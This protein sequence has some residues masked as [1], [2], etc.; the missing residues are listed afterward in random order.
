[1]KH[2]ENVWEDNNDGKSN[3]STSDGTENFS[4]TQAS[5]SISIRYLGYFGFYKASNDSGNPYGFL[6]TNGVLFDEAGSKID[7]IK[8]FYISKREL[9]SFSEHDWVT[10]EVRGTTAVNL[11]MA[12]TPDGL[13]MALQ[14]YWEHPCFKGSDDPWGKHSYDEHAIAGPLQAFLN[15]S[16]NGPREF[17]SILCECAAQEPERD[18]FLESLLHDPKTRPL[19]QNCFLQ[20]PADFDPNELPG[21]DFVKEK[22][23]DVL[24]AEDSWELIG[25]LWQKGFALKKLSPALQKKLLEGDGPGK[26]AFVAGL[27]TAEIA[28]LLT[29]ADLS[30]VSWE[31]SQ[32]L[33]ERDSS[34]FTSCFPPDGRSS[35]A[36]L[37]FLCLCGQKSCL[38]Y[39]QDWQNIA[40]LLER[41]EEYIGPFLDRYAPIAAEEQVLGL[42]AKHGAIRDA[43]LKRILPG[44][45]QEQKA[46]SSALFMKVMLDAELEAEWNWET[47]VGCLSHGISL[48]PWHPM[49]QKKLLEGD[50]PG[51]EAFVAG[52]STAEIAE[53]LSGADLSS[54]SWELAQSLYERDSSVFT[55][56]FPP[57]GRSSDSALF[58]LC[59]CGQTDGLVCIRD[60]QNMA[61]LLERHE[62]YV[63]PFLDRYAPIA[64]DE[65]VL[66]LLAKRS[67]IRNA[68]RKRIL[69]EK[70]QEQKAASSALFMKVILDEEL[71]AEWDW[72]TL[73]ECLLHD[74]SLEPW[75]PM[76]RKK[77]ADDPRAKG[78]KDFLQHL[79]AAEVQKLFAG[80]QAEE[81]SWELTETLAECLLHGISLEPWHLMI[82]K[83]LTDDPRAKGVK[84]FLQ[85]LD[86][87]EAQKLFAG[88]QAEEFSWELT[89]TL[90][91]LYGEA[92]C[93]IVPPMDDLPDGVL[94]LL[95]QC[96]R[97][98][99]IG[100]IANWEKLLKD[101]ETKYLC[102]FAQRFSGDESPDV[103][104][105][106]SRM[107]PDVLAN[108][109]RPL[110]E[111]E[112]SKALS[113]FADMDEQLTLAAAMLLPDNALTED[114]RRQR[115][116]TFRSDLPY[117][118]FDLESDRDRDTIW[119][120]AF[121]Q[122][123]ETRKYEGEEQLSSLLRRLKKIPNHRWP[124]YT[125][126]GSAHPG[127]ARTEDKCFC[128]GY[129]GNRAS[130]G[131]MPLRLLAACPAQGGQRCRAHRRFVLEPAL[132]A[133]AA[134]GTV[135]GT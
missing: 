135:Q 34:F 120:F 40:G 46:A 59:L 72:K 104:Y 82:R 11:Q 6:E 19:M 100:S 16:E 37:L 123:G 56:V 99:C 38:A 78:V 7:S 83:K 80:A 39:I 64:A 97:T 63:G 128:L 36:A 44:K 121:L 101:L 12:S 8:S 133:G 60:W 109:L 90:H 5:K 73:T 96:G 47:L 65:Q 93:E 43:A 124:Q 51:K 130:A 114:F 132:P 87:A 3:N 91:E 25:S 129:A 14:H 134:S 116:E 112:L 50:G 20:L 102:A 32:T 55:S 67:A 111:V 69:P 71:E 29:G 33:Y 26:E 57:D 18:A 28:E 31:L 2:D 103:A 75:H 21:F 113:K 30:S 126:M 117:A 45:G 105:V 22:V 86:A 76:I 15:K 61:G 1:M 108:I 84:D 9:R 110:E 42:L 88:A 35:D 27:S 62:E 118:V 79:D 119:E 24:I 81:F 13:R 106:L 54:V 131:S 4:S 70:G 94:L 107:T 48:E 92:L 10:F 125:A 53:L 85:H 122:D 95:Y 74:I 17:V 89:K 41:H 68:A 23:L 115:W 66:G 58:F 77:L 127:K 98:G 52:L 49:I